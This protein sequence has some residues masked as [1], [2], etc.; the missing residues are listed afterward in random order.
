MN[1]NAM[2]IS[3][4]NKS[5]LITGGSQ[6]IGKAAVAALAR[7]GA[8]VFCHYNSSLGS[9]DELVS[10]YSTIIPVQANLDSIREAERLFDEVVSKGGA[11]VLIN[12]AG[13]A[14]ESPISS[15][16]VSWVK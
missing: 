3:L 5:V 7:A 10:L 14:I 12:N 2:H 9:V 16:M 6:G 4:E 8:K 13:I 15:D 1:F 11:D